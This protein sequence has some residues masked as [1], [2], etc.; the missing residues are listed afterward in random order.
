MQ[1]TK[2]LVV[3]S[4]KYVSSMYSP[5]KG[6]TLFGKLVKYLGPSLASGCESITTNADLMKAGPMVLRALFTTMEPE[7]LVPTLNEVF[8]T[9]QIYADGGI[10]PIV[11]DKDFRGGY[12]HAVKLAKEVLE[13]QFV[14]F[15]DAIRDM[16]GDNPMVAA[17][18]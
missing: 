15:W 1:E 14:D 18:K 7:D 16:L 9:T 17:A 3:D 4:V 5:T 6:M 12:V 11:F 13:F 10:R 8:S 2:E